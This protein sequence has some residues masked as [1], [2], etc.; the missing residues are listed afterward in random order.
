M[1]TDDAKM[2]PTYVRQTATLSNHIHIV[3]LR[4]CSRKPR[5]QLR[6]ML[7]RLSTCVPHTDMPRSNTACWPTQVQGLATHPNRPTAAARRLETATRVLFLQLGAGKFMELSAPVMA[8]VGARA[9]I[10]V[11]GRSP[12]RESRG[13]SPL[14]WVRGSNPPPSATPLKLKAL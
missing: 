11:W 8:S 9:Y 2:A 12:Q 13:Q 10:G 1:A 5:R 3:V 7:A 4:T 6:S 14:C